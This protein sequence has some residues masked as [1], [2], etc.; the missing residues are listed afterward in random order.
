V[1]ESTFIPQTGSIFG[2]STVIDSV[3][4][5]AQGPPSRVIY[6]SFYFVILFCHSILSFRTGVFAGEESAVGASDERTRAFNAERFNPAFQTVQ[7]FPTEH[8]HLGECLCSLIADDL[9]W[10][11]PAALAG[12]PSPCWRRA[13]SR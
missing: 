12:V 1:T 7:T 13:F 9:Y 8:Y 4:A 11:R 6:L 5:N 2:G 3:I 10:I